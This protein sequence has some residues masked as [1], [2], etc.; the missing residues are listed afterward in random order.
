MLDLAY[1]NAT[2]Q[3]LTVASLAPLRELQDKVGGAPFLTPRRVMYVA[4]ADQESAF[5][6]FH[7]RVRMPGHRVEYHDGAFARSKVPIL[8]DGYVDFCAWK[9]EAMEFDVA[10]LLSGLLRQFRASGGRVEL[11]A[12]VETLEYGGGRWQLRGAGIAM[13]AARIINAAG[14]WADE[15]ASRAGGAPL[16]SCRCDG[17]SARCPFRRRPLTQAGHLSSTWTRS[18]T[19]SRGP[20]GCCCRPRMRLRYRPATLGLKT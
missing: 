3:A 20:A 15:I 6:Q 2:V 7:E 9:P 11:G 5:S 10:S 14:A 17:R 8:R 4:R 12:P 18:F 13:S 19:S 16:V 1:G